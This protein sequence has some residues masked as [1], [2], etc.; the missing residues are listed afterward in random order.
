MSVTNSQQLVLI[1]RSVARR[2]AGKVVAP[3]VDASTLRPY[4]VTFPYGV[5]TPASSSGRHRGEDHA[6]PVGSFALAVTWGRV[7]CV[8]TP[9]GNTV[10][11][12]EVETWGPAYG[13]HVV[14][15][16]ATGVYDYAACHLTRANV[17]PGDR[18]R[19]GQVIGYSGKTGN[20]TGPHVHLEARPAGGR[21]GSDINPRVVKKGVKT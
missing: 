1:R 21:L 12:S 6:C 8:T 15:R 10:P 2:K 11:G 20:A 16:T 18:V 9:A 19:P 13:C 3:V 4:P 5:P 14:I 17:A 7:V